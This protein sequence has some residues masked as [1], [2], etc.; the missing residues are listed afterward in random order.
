VSPLKWHAACFGDASK[1]P[2]DK[3]VKLVGIFFGL[4]LHSLIGLLVINA[5]SSANTTH[6]TDIK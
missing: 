5:K 1:W 3:H 6:F 2:K 4:S